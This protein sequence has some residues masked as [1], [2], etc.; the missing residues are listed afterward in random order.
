MD[1]EIDQISELMTIAVDSINDHSLA[2]NISNLY[3][4]TCE[5]YQ[6]EQMNF[7]SAYVN[8]I[9]EYFSKC[10]YT[11]IEDAATKKSKKMFEE[12]KNKYDAEQEKKLEDS[13]RRAI[14]GYVKSLHKEWEKIDADR[15]EMKQTLETERQKLDQEKLAFIKALEKK[16]EDIIQKFV[17]ERVKEELKKLGFNG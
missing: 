8:F 13:K 14:D 12:Y 7:R 17:D 6:Q 15:K 4:D 1:D 3:S 16:S 10:I 9:L 5:L 2:R 11:Q